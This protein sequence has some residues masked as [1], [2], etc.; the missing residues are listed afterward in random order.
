MDDENERYAHDDE[1]YAQ[2]SLLRLLRVIGRRVGVLPGPIRRKKKKSLLDLPEEMFLHICSF[3]DASTLVHGLS[4]V[5][6]QFYL[7]L[8]DADFLWKAR[9]NHVLPNASH[10]LLCSERPGKLF[11]KLSCVAIEKQ[12]ALWKHNSMK[13]LKLSKRYYDAT[14]VLLM[15][16]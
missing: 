10:S 6:K 13:K 16:V 14:S 3:L 5:C 4:L 12:A 8:K 7:I 15:P 2:L 1:E 9:I 11:W